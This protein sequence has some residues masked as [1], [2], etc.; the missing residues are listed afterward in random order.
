MDG[1]WT[2]GSSHLFDVA[3]AGEAGHG[4]AAVA[5]EML[6]AGLRIVPPPGVS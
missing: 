2:E 6:R 4:G 1:C 5:D 3:R